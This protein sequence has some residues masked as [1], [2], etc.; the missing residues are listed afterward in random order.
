MIAF[1]HDKDTNM[2]TLGCSLPNLAKLCLHKSTDTK[3]YPITEG[4]EDLLEKN[5]EAVVGG[6]SIV[7]TGKAVVDKTFTRKSTNLW[8]SIVEID[9]SRLLPYSMCQPMP[10]GLN[11]RWD[12]DSETSRFTPWQN[13]TRSFE[14]MVMFYFQRTW[15]DCKIE[16]F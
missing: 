5:Q 14:N 8:K 9:T 3:I 11:M 12:I 1:Y 15:P 6:S 10:T 16:S 7:F 4:D 13:K 2:L